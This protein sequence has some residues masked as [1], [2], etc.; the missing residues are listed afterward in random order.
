MKKNEV[1]LIESQVS[2]LVAKAVSI[3]INDGE[4]MKEA[5]EFLSMLNTRLERVVA[6]REK[7]TKPLN[8]A[9]KAERAR[10]KPLEVSLGSA[11]ALVRAGISKYQTQA[12]RIA[13]EAQEKVIARVGDGKGK[14]T[15]N[16][17]VRKLREIDT[18]EAKIQTE[19]GDVRF[20]IVKKFEVMDITLL[21]STYLLPNEPMIRKAMG[22]GIEVSG[23]R[24]YEEQ[25]VVNTR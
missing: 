9:L 5:V 12:V 4:S 17:A 22:E 7:V 8:E 3:I 1:A 25:Q 2:P 6:E 16:T 14:F 21:P 10:W 18:P 15:L 11:I 24:Y 20:R 13:K 19:A 23:V